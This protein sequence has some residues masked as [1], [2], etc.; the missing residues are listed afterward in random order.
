MECR[1]ASDGKHEWKAPMYDHY[2]G[3]TKQCAVC[4]K[5]VKC[6]QDGE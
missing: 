5:I 6:Y 1:K 4:G 2:W 3:W